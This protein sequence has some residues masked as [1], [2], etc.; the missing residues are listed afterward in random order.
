MNP[1]TK[2]GGMLTRTGD[3]CLLMVGAHVAHDCII[4][5]S[6]ILVN[7]ATLGGH[8]VI[9]D[10]AIVGGLSAIHQFVRV[11]KHAMI[12]GMSGVENDVI[13]YGSVTGNRAYLSGLNIVGL[14]RRD[15]P[16]DEIHELRSAY[17]MLF[18]QEGTMQERLDDV[19]EMFSHCALVRD[20]VDFMRADSSRAVCQPKLDRD[21]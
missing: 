3:N 11:G 15:F 19:A 2:G 17:R 5:D 12:G 8:V 4:G 20:I 13:P 7:N 14:K 16:R 9:D 10:Y 21:A 18:A 1:G 6:V